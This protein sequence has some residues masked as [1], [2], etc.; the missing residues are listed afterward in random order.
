MKNNF[1]NLISAKIEDIEIVFYSFITMHL[2]IL[3]IV[4]HVNL[5]VTR[6]AGPPSPPPSARCCGRR[7]RPPERGR[8]RSGVEAPPSSTGPS[9]PPAAG[10]RCGPASQPGERDVNHRSSQLN[11]NLSNGK[12][13]SQL[14]NDNRFS[15]MLWCYL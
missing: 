6:G 13:L 2:F 3:I 7:S 4:V 5:L 9:A 14:Q 15:I 11:N 8:E 10:T 1:F 12:Q